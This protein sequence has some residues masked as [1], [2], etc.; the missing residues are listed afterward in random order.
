MKKQH[1]Q[2]SET[3]RTYLEDLLR[4]GELPVKIYRR[5]LALLELDRG[6]T[7]TAVAETVQVT[8]ITV[9]TWSKKYG[10]VGL[11]MLTD[12]PRSG[13]P[14]EI[15][16]AQ[17]AKVTALACSDP[18]EGYARWSLRLLAEKVVE[19]GYVDYISHTQV[20]DILKK[21]T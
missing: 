2:L 17:R 21:T 7:Y 20:G 16:G 11:T 4:K 3:N 10:E 1:V 6:K 13:R 19:L 18:P 9:S 15:D 8:N 14:L 12:Q 5:A